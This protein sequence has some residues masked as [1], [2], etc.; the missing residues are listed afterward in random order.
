MKLKTL[1]KTALTGALLGSTVNAS[2]A[3]IYYSNV[4]AD[5]GSGLTSEFIDPTDAANGQGASGFNGYFIETFDLDTAM[6]G[7]S[8]ISSS[9][10][11]IDEGFNGTPAVDCGLNSLNA[12]ISI[13]TSTN[14]FEISSASGSG[15]AAPANDNT[16]FGYTPASGQG[17]SVNNPAWLEIDYGTFLANGAKIDYLGFYWGSIDAYNDFEFYDS[18]GNVLL[19]I[20]GASLLDNCL[21]GNQSLPCSNRYVNIDFDQSEAFS[22]F[23]VT[24]TGVAGEFDNIVVGLNTRSVSEP[25]TV[26]VLGM[27][28]IGLAVRRRRLFN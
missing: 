16:C 7:F 5:D 12:N 1:L 18:A 24:S 3:I 23:R 4:D 15:R 25:A 8:R 19:T 11:F 2:A 14:G 6:A 10:A 21:A 26:M 28:L 20:T 9:G 17:V 27:G 22:K 13:N